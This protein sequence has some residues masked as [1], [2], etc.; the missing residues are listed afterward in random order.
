MQLT[1]LCRHIPGRVLRTVRT[2]S[3]NHL[4]LNFSFS[5]QHS[6]RRQIAASKREQPPP[7][8]GL[9]PARHER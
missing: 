3:L 1:F 5:N 8:R 7:R 6:D 4:F 9:Q 2:P